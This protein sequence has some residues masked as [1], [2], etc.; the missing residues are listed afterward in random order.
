MSR[1]IEE[2][3]R[4]NMAKVRDSALAAGMLASLRIIK[5]FYDQEDKTAEEILAEI[6]NYIENSLA[7]DTYYKQPKMIAEDR[8]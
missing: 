6:K 8:K 2:I 1:T 3:A 5:T 7:K 4:E